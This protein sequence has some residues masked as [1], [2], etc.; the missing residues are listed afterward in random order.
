L[1]HERAIA[2]DW[3]AGNRERAQTAAAKLSLTSPHF[4]KRW[5]SVSAGLPQ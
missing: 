3:L 5:E 1:R 2:F 4:K